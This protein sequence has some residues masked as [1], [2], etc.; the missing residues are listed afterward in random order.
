MSKTW[1]RSGVAKVPKFERCASPQA[2]TVNPVVGC[3]RQIVRHH[4]GGAAVEGKRRG[5][6]APVA[7]RDEIRLA[8]P[9]LR[10][11][12]DRAGPGGRPVATSRRG[13]SAAPASAAACPRPCVR[14]SAAPLAWPPRR[15]VVPIWFFP[16]QPCPSTSFATVNSPECLGGRVPRDA[17][18]HHGGS[19][20]PRCRPHSHGG[21]TSGPS[22]VRTISRRRFTPIQRAAGLTKPDHRFG[23]VPE[24][25]R[26]R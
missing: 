23:L 20:S 12:A 19:Q 3:C 2:C 9:I 13:T 25:R 26:V 6:H 11:A 21:L 24:P 4:D 22:Q 5:Q 10:R 8:G 15:S 18:R 17:N 14:R 7:D 1:L 16:L